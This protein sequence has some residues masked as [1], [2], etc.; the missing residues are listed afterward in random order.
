M[1]SDELYKK[2]RTEIDKTVVYP[3]E[4]LILMPDGSEHEV[5]NVEFSPEGGT[6][7][8]VAK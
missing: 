1:D 2:V 7:Y 3:V 8:I 5:A 6:F 4:V